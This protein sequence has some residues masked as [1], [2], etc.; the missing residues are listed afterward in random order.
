MVVNTAKMT[1][2][3]LLQLGQ[4]PQGVKLELVYG[5]TAVSASPTPKHA[6][7]AMMLATIIN[8]HI[9][10]RKLGKFFSDVDTL[11]D[12]Y[13]VRRPDLLYYSNE[14]RHLVGEK[15]MTGPPDLAIEVVSPSSVEVDREDKFEQYRASRVKFYW[16]V[17]LIDRTLEAW[18]LKPSRYVPIGRGQDNQVVRLAP[19]TDLDISLS[20]LWRK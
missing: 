16:I 12:E 7:T 20:E 19:F 1:A 17:D 4:D 9:S 10:K 8:I 18:E 13:N 6:Y 3:Q 15:F 5:E 11:L 2:R 14:N